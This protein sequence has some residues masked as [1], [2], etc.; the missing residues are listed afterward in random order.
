MATSTEGRHVDVGH[1]AVTVVAG[2]IP[3][4][5]DAQDIPF[6]DVQKSAEKT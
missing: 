3:P 1:E 4:P 2:L 6:D 5:F